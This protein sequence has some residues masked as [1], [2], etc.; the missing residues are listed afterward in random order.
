MAQAIPMYVR[1]HSQGYP[2]VGTGFDYFAYRG[3]RVVEG[4][5]IAT[6]GECLVGAR[7]AASLGVGPGD[8]IISSPES[9][10]D[11]AGV[12]PLKMPI[13]GVLAFAD[14]PDDDAIFVDV[15]TA[16]VIEGLGHGHMDMTTNEAQPGVL[17]VEEGNVVANAS[18]LSHTEITPE[19]PDSFPFH[20]DPARL[21]TAALVNVPRLRKSGVA[22]RGR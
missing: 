22:C 12:Y 8:A 3:L 20:G 6:L 17:A 10:F 2:I 7:V 19:N 21:P 18:V 9:V 13:A 4:R 16:W 5:Q 14:S 15:K 1:F 11:I